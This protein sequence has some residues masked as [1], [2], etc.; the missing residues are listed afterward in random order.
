MHYKQKTI[1]YT[2]KHFI[3]AFLML[4]TSFFS[5]AQVTK[6]DSLATTQI[7]EKAAIVKDSIVSKTEKIEKETIVV[8]DSAVVEGVNQLENKVLEVKDS[9]AVLPVENKKAAMK[10]AAPK[11][12]KLVD[13]VV[14]VSYTHLTLPTIYSV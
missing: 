4:G 7:Q 1:P 11:S 3:I 8:K 13:G 5:Y 6:V 14:A 2:I 12:R 9:T 10:K